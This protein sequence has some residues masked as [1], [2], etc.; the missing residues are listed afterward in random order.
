MEPYIRQT[1]FK[2]IA[3]LLPENA[4]IEDQQST[5]KIAVVLGKLVGSISM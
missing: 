4:H 5:N 1:R 2:N 3:L